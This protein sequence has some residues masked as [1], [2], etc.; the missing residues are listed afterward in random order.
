[1]TSASDAAD[2]LAEHQVENGDN[3]HARILWRDCKLDKSVCTTC[4]WQT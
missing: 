2:D 3:A 4:D 1:V